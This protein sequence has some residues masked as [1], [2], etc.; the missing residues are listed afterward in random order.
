MPYV[1]LALSS[2][3]YEPIFYAHTKENVTYYCEAACYK[4]IQ[5]LGKETGAIQ[6]MEIM[7]PYESLATKPV[8]TQYEPTLT[9][10]HLM[11]FPLQEQDT[12]YL[13]SI[14]NFF[15][16]LEKQPHKNEIERLE[17]AIVSGS[18][19]QVPNSL[20]E[21]LVAFSFERVLP[22]HQRIRA[23]FSPHIRPFLKGR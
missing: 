23:S 2:R 8:T 14:F 22:K 5:M 21:R 3:H 7:L 15:S 12:P 9:A 16:Q 1:E 11:D 18:Y 4:W 6:W 17:Y 10:G 13:V 20:M 19:P